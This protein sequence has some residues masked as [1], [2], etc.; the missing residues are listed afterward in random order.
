[1]GSIEGPLRVLPN[2]ETVGRTGTK[3][4][5]WLTETVGLDVTVVDKRENED[6]DMVN[7]TH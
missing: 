4:W 7:R 3:T 6:V 2:C 1:M 5:T